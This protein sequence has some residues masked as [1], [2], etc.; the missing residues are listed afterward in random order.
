MVGFEPTT[1]LLPGAMN[2]ENV[3]GCSIHLSYTVKLLFGILLGLRFVEALINGLF[4][5]FWCRLAF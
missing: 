1:S 4:I 3:R 5:G 2:D